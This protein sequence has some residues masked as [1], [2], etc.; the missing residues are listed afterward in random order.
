MNLRS[1]TAALLLLAVGCGFPTL[2][3]EFV[4]PELLRQGPA[5]DPAAPAVVLYRARKV[6][7]DWGVGG[8]YTQRLRHEVIRIQTESGLRAASHKTFFWS[9]V[10]V[11]AVRARIFQP[12]GTVVEVEDAQ[13][14]ADTR[15]H[16]AQDVNARYL[17]FPG[18]RVGSVIELV[19]LVTTPGFATAEV[20]DAVD[21]W[22]VQ[23]FTFELTAASNLR[24][25]T[26]MFNASAA[27]RSESPTDDHQ[28]W[29]YRLAGIAPPPAEEFGPHRS[30]LVP[31]LAFRGRGLVLSDRLPMIRWIETWLDI[32]DRD[33]IHYFSAAMSER[34]FPRREFSGCPTKAC[35][36]ERALE[37]V[38]AQTRPGGAWDR[39]RP[40]A[41]V[42]ESGQASVTER[43]VL[44]RFLLADVGF[45]AW[46]AWTTDTLSRQVQQD[47]PNR[48]RFNR[49]LVYLPPQA[50]VAAPTFIDPDCDFC[51]PGQL[52]ARSLG[53]QAL[54]VRV[55]GRVPGA[56][57]VESAWLPTSG[58]KAK[59]STQRDVHQVTIADSGDAIDRLSMTL[60]GLVAQTEGRTR[61]ARLSGADDTA[62]HAL[63]RSLSPLAEVTT[64]QPETCDARLGV[65]ASSVDLTIPAA[66]VRDG[67]RLYVPLTFLRPT[68]ERTFSQPERLTDI[69]F[70]V[71]D[72][73]IEEVA[74]LVVPP[75]YALLE[76]PPPLQASTPGASATVT[77]EAQVNGARVSRVL[78]RTMGA[79]PRARYP[80]FQ[81]VFGAFR[82]A[83]QLVL[84]FQ[85]RATEA[86][87]GG[88]ATFR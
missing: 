32:V 21:V 56:E 37:V 68:H 38:R 29:T 28:R 57:V 76:V 13:R 27:V 71:D 86:S 24:F 3:A 84:T 30:F 83:R 2:R 1:V 63:V 36:A 82:S 46:L 59:P 12:D 23:Q 33:A 35:L 17:S 5:A 15:G 45:E 26:A 87:P 67:D 73:R 7:F 50:G 75:G 18:A 39:G 78:E 34:F 52:P 6:L 22:P 20:E 62:R 81:K 65:C 54:A 80:E 70:G 61:A 51:A 14:W 8:G 85:R 42:A 53:A 25:E 88:S 77:V 49:L 66:A 9:N 41:A 64:H 11:V 60:E 44:L 19:S 10:E 43:A 48:S 47:L 74:T 79:Y 16:G 4:D 31:A 40:L 72:E 58:A 55:T 69:H